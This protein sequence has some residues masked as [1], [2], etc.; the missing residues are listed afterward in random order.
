MTVKKMYLPPLHFKISILQG[1]FYFI[2]QYIGM[3]QAYFHHL[4][5]SNLFFGARN[6]KELITHLPVACHHH[7]AAEQ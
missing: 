4:G 2:L 1:Q 7:H 3:K 5:E 6:T